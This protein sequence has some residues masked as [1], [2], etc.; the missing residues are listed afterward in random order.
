MTLHL[1]VFKKKK[2]SK[3]KHGYVE[4]LDVHHQGVAARRS[5]GVGEG[6]EEHH[7]WGLRDSRMDEKRGYNALWPLVGQW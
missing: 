6:D 3:T 4:L 1:P 5:R 7:M 2:E